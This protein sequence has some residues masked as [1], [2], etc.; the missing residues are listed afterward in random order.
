MWVSAA[1]CATVVV[2]LT[3]PLLAFSDNDDQALISKANALFKPLPATDAL[4]NNELTP[5]R[6]ALGKALFYETR[7]SS[8]GRLGCVTCHNPAYHG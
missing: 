3:A 6:V 4:E 2:A 5:R 1:V 8:D 7:V